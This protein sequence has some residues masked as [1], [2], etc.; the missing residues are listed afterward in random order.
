MKTLAQCEPPDHLEQ[1]R[2]DILNSLIGE[3]IL[4]ILGEPDSLLAV[5]VRHL[6]A[7]NYR[8]NVLVGPHVASARVVHS[9]FLRADSQGNIIE[10]TP[11]ISKLY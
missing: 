6:W 11:T 10:S 2:R 9:Y 4:H 7:V 5:Q 1:D 3:R 8:V